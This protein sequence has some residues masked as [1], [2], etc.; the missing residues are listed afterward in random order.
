ME[1]AGSNV[2]HTGTIV[3]STALSWAWLRAARRESVFYASLEN[4]QPE[5]TEA[6][7]VRDMNRDGLCSRAVTAGETAFS[8]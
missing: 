6:S 7:S 5:G 2:Q 1:A 4:R 8:P 3:A